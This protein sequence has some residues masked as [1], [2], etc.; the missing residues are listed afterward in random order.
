VI[1]LVVQGDDVGMCHAVNEA[2][3]AAWSAGV[4]TQV[5]VMAACPWV[6]EAT[7]MIRRLDIPAG[8]HQT[9]TCEWDHLR[10]GPLTPTT[11]L[12][13]PDGT[14][15]ATVALAQEAV[16]SAP[17]AAVNELL[18]QAARLTDAGV[19]LSYLDVHMGMAAPSVYAEVAGRLRLPFLY[20]GLDASLRF[21]SVAMLSA[22]PAADKKAWLLTHLAGL[23]EG[24]HLLVSHPGAASAEL[25][26]LTRPD[27]GPWPWAAEYRVSD[28]A[29][30]TDPE[31][32]QA[33]D[34]LGIKLVA[35]ADGGGE[36]SG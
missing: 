27:S 2:V 26:S 23:G 7:A 9:L 4:L 15:P 11:E 20:P 18:A 25:S 32:R 28:L 1:E 24:R 5:S 22:R 33:I 31:V 29:V 14:F 34:E 36:T 3:G 19:A 8:L 30:L 13:R 35:V 16:A 17:A 10:W 6:D 12:A 21:A